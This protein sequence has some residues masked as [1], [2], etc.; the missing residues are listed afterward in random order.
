MDEK[1]VIIIVVV[2]VALLGI[3][4]YLYS[5]NS[6]G[7]RRC[8]L[9]NNCFGLTRTPVDFVFKNPGF[10]KRNPH[11]IADPSSEYQPLD[12]GP[13]DL[14]NDLRRLNEND[15]HI[16]RDR[17]CDVWNSYKLLSNDEKNRHDLLSVGD[18]GERKQLESLPHP[19]Y[20]VSNDCSITE[21][22]LTCPSDFPK[23]YGGAGYLLRDRIGD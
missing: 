23:L 5:R 21:A 18:Y 10:H 6:D 13:I 15:G 16:G 17:F 2:V 7:Y 11:W 12:H 3:W 4:A 1:T 22:N 14:Q 20:G 19:R 9:G 8:P